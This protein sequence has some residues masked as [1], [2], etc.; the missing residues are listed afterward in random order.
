[1]CKLGAAGGSRH[2]LV[3]NFMAEFGSMEG[4]VLEVE[5]GAC[6]KRVRAPTD[7]LLKFSSCGCP[8]KAQ[9]CLQ[10]RKEMAHLIG[11][12]N[13]Q[14]TFVH[15]TVGP[16]TLPRI[17]LHRWNQLQQKFKTHGTLAQNG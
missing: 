5:C 14:K 8:N 10:N 1:M 2:S 13:D 17:T 6:G 12:Q 7:E 3:E 16:S 9:L 4:F 15:V 11:A